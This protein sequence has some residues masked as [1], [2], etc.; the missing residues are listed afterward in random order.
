MAKNNY[1]Q[2]ME[3]R[4]QGNEEAWINLVT[5]QNI[6]RDAIKRIFKEMVNGGYDY[7]KYGRYFLDSR[8]LENLIVAAGT[9]LEY[10]T[11]LS[12]AVSMFRGYSPTYPNIGAHLTHVQNL[13]YIYSVLYNKLLEVRS[14]YNIAALVEVSPLT[15]SYRTDI[16]NE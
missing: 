15:Y 12:N 10:Y 7:E 5:P 1:F 4:Y 14:T 16:N 2:D 8:F 9:K 3:Q 11:L 6:Q 13:N